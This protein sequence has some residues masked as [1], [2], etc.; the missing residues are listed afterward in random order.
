FERANVAHMGDLMFHQRHPVVDR[1]AGA[2][3]KN[4]ITVLERTVQDHA[5]DTVYIFG[6]AN[7][8]LPVVGGRA[9]LEQFRDYFE[10]LLSLVEK[11]ARA[12]RSRDDS[13]GT[14]GALWGFEAYGPYGSRSP[15]GA[16]ACACEGVVE[17]VA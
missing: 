11:Q 14:R 15:R 7:T 8:A 13:I 17:G 3:I 2:T 16:L 1:A 10:A 4:W 6:H 5:N 9:E 12:G